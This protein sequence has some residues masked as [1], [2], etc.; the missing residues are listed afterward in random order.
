MSQARPGY[1]TVQDS[2]YV[3]FDPAVFFDK[4]QNWGI[5]DTRNDL[6]MAA[7]YGRG[8][9]PVLVGQ[10]GHRPDLRRG[11]R[12][13]P[14][15]VMY[16]GPVI[17][18]FGHWLLSS[19]CRLWPILEGRSPAIR[20][21]WHASHP[22][23]DWLATRYIA[24]ALGALGFE[25][26]DF[27]VPTDCVTLKSLIVPQPSFVEQHSAHTVY[28]TLCRRIGDTLITY[29]SQ[30]FSG[31]KV[32]LSKVRVSSGVMRVINERFL[33]QGLQSQGFTVVYPE[34]LSLAEQ[35]ELFASADLIVGFAGS[36][37][38]VSAFARCRGKQ[39]ILSPK[40]FV[41]SNFKLIDAIS[42]SAPLYLDLSEEMTEHGS[43]G[44]FLTNFAFKSPRSIAEQVRDWF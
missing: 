27:L 34:L 42:D 12:V 4:D 6:V 5:Y 23:D 17:P 28:S 25:S 1:D 41:N 8:P 29:P 15:T 3:P 35:I 21:L 24:A 7:S 39:I 31:R 9:G 19:L 11:D 22:P 16:G 18:Q 40:P 20:V 43:Y 2:C 44:G 13:L 26:D 30:S 33:E 38:H 36:A 10:S 37:F 32:Y 14:E